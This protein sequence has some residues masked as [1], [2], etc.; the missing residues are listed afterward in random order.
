MLGRFEGGALQDTTDC[1]VHPAPRRVRTLEE[2]IAE[3]PAPR[4]LNEEVKARIH[5]IAQKLARKRNAI[6]DL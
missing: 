4:P 3:V 1:Y 5:T 2:E 6:I